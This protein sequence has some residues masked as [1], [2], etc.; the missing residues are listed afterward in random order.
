MEKLVKIHLPNSIYK[1]IDRRLSKKDKESKRFVLN[2]LEENYSHITKINR[3]GY[4]VNFKYCNVYK[5]L[6]V[7]ISDNVPSYNTKN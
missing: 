7:K 6:T 3:S 1:L 2:L 5:T 4:F